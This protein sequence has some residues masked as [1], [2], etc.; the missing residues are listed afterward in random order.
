MKTENLKPIFLTSDQ[1]EILYDNREKEPEDREEVPGFE[2]W[3]ID[4]DTST[5]EYDSAKASMTDYEI[6]LYNPE[7]KLMGTAIGGYY[8][9][10]CGEKFNYDLTFEPPEPETPE[11]KFNDFLLDVSES[12]DSLKKKITKVKKYIEKL[13]A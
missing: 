1:I 3:S 7:G 6:Y 10:G 13:E 11:S 2:G 4:T 5:G 12:D 8:N 9:G